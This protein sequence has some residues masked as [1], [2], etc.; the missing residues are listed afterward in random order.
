MV[1]QGVPAATN[2]QEMFL[3]DR[4]GATAPL[5]DRLRTRL[6]QG[7]GRCTRDENDYALVLLAGR[8]LLNW[9]ANQSNAKGLIPELQAEIAFG[10]DNSN[11]RT[12]SDFL[13]L[14]AAFLAQ[15]QDWSPADEEIIAR[16]EECAVV[17]DAVAQALKAAVGHEVRYVYALWRHEF[18]RAMIL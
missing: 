11:D 12:A 6:T 16:R 13:E 9:C 2:L 7:L 5:R 3:F 8:D 17:D 18:D 4:L 1:I 14:R 15:T 10:L